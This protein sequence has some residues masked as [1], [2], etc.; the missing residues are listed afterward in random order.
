MNRLYASSDAD[1][2][3]PITKRYVDDFRMGEIKNV[4]IILTR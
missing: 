4:K 1:I 3:R 2:I